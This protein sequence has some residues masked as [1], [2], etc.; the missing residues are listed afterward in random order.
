MLNGVIECNVV[1]VCIIYGFDG[2][3]NADKLNPRSRSRLEFQ[4]FMDL[5]NESFT[6]ST[7]ILNF[8]CLK[9]YTTNLPRSSTI[10][11]FFISIKLQRSLILLIKLGTLG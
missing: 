7:S 10:S 3:E 8:R 6:V 11:L 9:D 4:E 1:Q 2:I 5:V